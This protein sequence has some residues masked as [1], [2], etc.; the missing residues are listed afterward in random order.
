MKIK[1]FIKLEYVTLISRIV[2][3]THFLRCWL[4]CYD[5]YGI[6]L[7]RSSCKVFVDTGANINTITRDFYNVLVSQGLKSKFTKGPKAFKLKL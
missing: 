3:L 4:L 1:W 5:L 7:E 2:I 6:L